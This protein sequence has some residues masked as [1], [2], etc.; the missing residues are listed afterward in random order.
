MCR[1]Q[2][3]QYFSSTQI[4]MLLPYPRIFKLDENTGLQR[5]IND[6]LLIYNCDMGDAD[7]EGGM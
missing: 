7:V 1:H 6:V 3:G 4:A 5:T 2:G